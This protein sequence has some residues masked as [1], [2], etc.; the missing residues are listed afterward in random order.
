[1]LHPRGYQEALRE[2][3]LERSTNY[4]D[5]LAHQFTARLNRAANQVYEDH[6]TPVR[7]S[8]NCGRFQ[9]YGHQETGI[10]ALGDRAL[11]LSTTV[12]GTIA[13]GSDITLDFIREG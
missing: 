3:A 11:P 5:E 2:I 1:M 9:L 10:V 12:V 6:F 7:R 13:G 4:P 8:P